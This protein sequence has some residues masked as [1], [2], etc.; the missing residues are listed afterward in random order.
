MEITSEVDYLD[1]QWNELLEKAVVYQQNFYELLP[2]WTVCKK[3]D[4]K[5]IKQNIGY[6]ICGS[7]IF[8]STSDSNNIL[9]IDTENI[10]DD[11]N[12]NDLVQYCPKMEKIISVILQKIMQYSSEPNTDFIHYGIIYNMIFRNKLTQQCEIK[13]KEEIIAVPVFKIKHYND[14]SENEVFS[15]WY[16]DIQGRIYKSWE[17]YILNN[18]FPKCTMVYP[19][20]GY[21]QSNPDFQI[22]PD[23]S[24]V[25][26]IAKDSYECSSRAQV[27][28]TVNL[29][30]NTVGTSVTVGI[31][32]ASFFTP[33][34]P[35]VAAAGMTAM[36]AQG[37][38]TIGKCSSELYDKTIH[39]ES[40]SP[41]DQ[42]NLS[43][44]LGIAGCTV[45]LVFQG[46][47]V[48][49][50]KAAA[51]GI[52][53]SRVATTAYDIMIVTNV[54]INL[55]G[56]GYKS[57]QIYNKY[58]ESERVDIQDIF[59]LGTHVLFFMNSVINIKFANDVI[60]QTQG[61][62][63]KEFE[64]NLRDEN[65]LKR[66]EYAQ[67]KASTEFN[68]NKIEENAAII[69]NFKYY[70]IDDV[71]GTSNNSF[72]TPSSFS[73]NFVE[74]KLKLNGITLLDPMS[75]VVTLGK[76]FL[77][78]IKESNS[79]STEDTHSLIKIL[80]MLLTNFYKSNDCQSETKLPVVEDFKMIIDELKRIKN[81]KDILI[82]IFNTSVT[83]LKSKNKIEFLVEGCRYVWD[84]V[85][86]NMR[87][88]GY[89]IFT[90]SENSYDHN[91]CINYMRCLFVSI[92]DAVDLM[93]QRFF[94]ALQQYVKMINQNSSQ[95][96]FNI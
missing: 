80:E 58:K 62:V 60:R 23:C 41:F 79:Q 6:A 48:L 55:I 22:T 94:N 10:T 3:N 45:G 78:N 5:L 17:D 83:I 56:V 49:L 4:Y 43:A 32:V 38:W 15:I 8:E 42:N 47:T 26:L 86:Q 35:L 11:T 84:Y 52:M 13:D 73:L 44:W 85:K 88:A 29:A 93:V 74:G 9:S 61:L 67:K 24:T 92:F 7:P 46:S 81:S 82:F 31:G 72:A 2:D 34:G 90:T 77:R 25:W 16:L 40:I 59:Y 87:E 36:T 68:T 75:L 19:K 95:K 91:S 39:D 53:V 64:Q 27:M 96:Y 18:N 50:R 63:L 51:E 20:D 21:Y 54:S 30:V 1:V 76:T 12:I 37:V 33:V 28:S 69:R 89:E 70:T 66:Y 71:T 57:V 65:L 14:N